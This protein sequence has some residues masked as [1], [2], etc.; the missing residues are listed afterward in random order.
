MT[1]AMHGGKQYAPEKE[2]ERHKEKDVASKFRAL[3]KQ[4]GINVDL[5]LDELAETREKRD[6]PLGGVIEQINA[7][8]EPPQYGIRIFNEV[9]GAPHLPHGDESSSA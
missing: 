7:E 1:V 2:M 4:D 3:F 5:K 8:G 6:T 9:A